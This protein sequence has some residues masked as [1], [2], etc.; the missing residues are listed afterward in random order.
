MSARVDG[1][2]LADAVAARHREVA[3]AL[4]GLDQLDLLEG[5][6]L[7]GWNRLTIACH[8]RYGANASRRMTEDTVAGRQAAFYPLGRAEQRAATLEPGPNETP[9][10][11][12]ASLDEE[13]CRLD[14]LWATI[15]HDHWQL[16][17]N[18]PE[19]NQ[20]LGSVTLWTVAILR[21]TEVE[22]HG[23]D[24]DL[25]LSPW[26]T[27]FVSAAL[28]MRLNWLPSRRS[29]HRSV[30]E[31]VDGTWAFVRTDGPSFL[32]ESRGGRVEVSESLTA[33][34]AD[35]AFVGTGDQ[36]LRFILGRAPLS[37]LEVRGDEHHAAS[38]LAVFPAP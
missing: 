6:R 38:F 23:Y 30:G 20:D 10:G 12:I 4:V 32:I 34:P 37:G 29:N 27:T 5:S 2:A 31:S 18:E 24:L 35:A 21:L 9:A 3:A 22:V 33:P 26:S 17:V 19:D 14:K 1:A 25:N 11:V 8:L 13:S 16:S 7:P 28:P 15:G 36:L